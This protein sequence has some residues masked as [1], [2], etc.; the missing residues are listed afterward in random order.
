[1]IFHWHDGSWEDIRM[2]TAICGLTHKNLQPYS[3]S[4]ERE[5]FETFF[6]TPLLVSKYMSMI[7]NV[8]SS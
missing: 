6:K 8:L 2:G 3:V 5:D 4:F 7:H 1:M